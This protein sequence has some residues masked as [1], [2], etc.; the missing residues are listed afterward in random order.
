VSLLDSTGNWRSTFTVEAANVLRQLRT[1]ITSLFDASPG[2][3]R[4]SRDVQKLLGVDARL[5][6]QVFKL[7][8]PGDALSL[9]PHVPSAA[10]MKRLLEAAKEH[11]ISPQR[12]EQVRTAYEK[13]EQ[14]VE[15]HAGDRTSFYSMAR[16]LS[17]DDETAQTDLQHRKAIFQGHSHY[18]GMQ[19]Q[20][21]LFSVM[22]KPGS[23]P[24]RYDQVSLR[25]KL[26]LRRLRPDADVIVDTVRVDA[27]AKGAPRQDFFD[28]EAAERYNAAILPSFCSQPLPQ[29]RTMRMDENTSYSQLVGDAV[30]R[31]GAVDMVF[32]Q[33]WRD[34][35]LYVTKDRQRLEMG[36]DVGIT[37][38]TGLVAVDFL[39]HRPTFPRAE[40]RFVVF[41]EAR[42]LASQN[43]GQVKLPFRE[44]IAHLGSAPDAV[45][46]RDMPR[47]LELLEFACTKLDCNLNEFDVYRVRVEYPLLDTLL[48]LRFDFPGSEQ[49]AA[50]QA[51]ATSPDP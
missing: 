23:V 1:A 34:V 7:A 17:D 2:G 48:S 29:L 15:I 49:L 14:L 9:A 21:Y 24:N 11:G 39:V 3:V 18:F 44:R 4:K 46:F 28:P 25:A 37:A 51:S 32:G 19:L 10:S 36:I 35:P 42:G 8:G 50:Q 47:Y 26:G 38:P 13:F 31:L 16:G 33:A 41:S 43:R 40:S 12:V 5:S 20:T 6:W 45:V 22:L 30:G 27:P